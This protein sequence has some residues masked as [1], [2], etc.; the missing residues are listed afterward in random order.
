MYRYAYIHIVFLTTSPTRYPPFPN[1]PEMPGRVS[2]KTDCI[3]V[4]GIC[5]CSVVLVVCLCVS[6]N[7]PRGFQSFGFENHFRA[8]GFSD[9]G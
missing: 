1:V 6:S 4:R 7:L 8:W 9:L 5:I 2:G 3:Y